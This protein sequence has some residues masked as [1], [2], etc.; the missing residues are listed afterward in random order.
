MTQISSSPPRL[1]ACR[2]R[3]QRGPILTLSNMDTRLRG[4]DEFGGYASPVYSKLNGEKVMGLLEG[5]VAII[6]GAGG[7]LGSSYARLLAREGAAIVVNDFSGEQAEKVVAQ[8]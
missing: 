7:G 4:N 6:T 1:T 2:G 3:L 8:I 5:K